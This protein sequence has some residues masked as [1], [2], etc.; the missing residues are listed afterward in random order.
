[1]EEAASGGLNWVAVIAGAVISFLVGWVWYSPKGFGARWAEGVGVRLEDASKMPPQA[2]ILQFAGLFLLSWV[3]G[4]TA[5]ANALITAIL[6][7][8][9]VV[10][11]IVANGYFAQKSQY[12]INTEGAYIAACGGIMIVCQALL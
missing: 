2:M 3:I 8:L 10:C 6:F 11:L 9:A 5:A 4:L 1:M 7:I 12:A